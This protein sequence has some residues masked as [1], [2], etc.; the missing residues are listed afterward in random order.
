[1][2]VILNA[3]IREKLKFTDEIQL[4]NVNGQ[5]YIGC[6]M[7]KGKSIEIHG[8]PG[9]DMACYLNGGSIEVFGNGQDAI[10]N[11]M[12]GGT[13]TVHGH[14]GDALGYAMRDG[15]ILIKE[16]IGS[17]GGI[18]MKEFGAMKPVIVIGNRAGD[19]LGEYMAGGVIL[20]LGLGLKDG[21][22]LFGAHCATGMH[23]GKMFFRG[24]SFDKDFGGNLVLQ[25][26]DENDLEELKAYVKSYCDSFA[27]DYNSVMNSKFYKLTPSSSR[28]YA[29]LYTSMP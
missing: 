3:E 25:D 1:M 24:D 4:N 5:R 17:R 12:N 16:R 28:P 2:Q 19:F 7:D 9:N 22:E 8:T 14:A 23:G 10:G 15:M 13:V 21:D 29:N 6:G 26:A 11:T 20:V 27:A 18:H